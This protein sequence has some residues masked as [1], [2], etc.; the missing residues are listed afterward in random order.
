MMNYYG[1]CIRFA[2]SSSTPQRDI[3]AIGF[4]CEQSTIYVTIYAVNNC[5][6]R[7]TS[8]HQD[9]KANSGSV[10]PSS[11]YPVRI[12][13]RSPEDIDFQKRSL[14]RCVDSSSSTPI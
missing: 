13:V 3:Y 10:L 14:I 6:S 9:S 5:S 4:V 2:S 11:M 12:S 1:Y 7:M 8:C